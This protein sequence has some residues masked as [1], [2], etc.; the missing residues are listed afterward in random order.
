MSSGSGKQLSHGQ[1]LF[2][3]ERTS[4]HC[5]CT[6]KSDIYLRDVKIWAIQMHRY[7]WNTKKTSWWTTWHWDTFFSQILLQSSSVSMNQPTNQ[8]SNQTTNQPTNQL[9]SW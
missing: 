3:P 5:N 4:V 8:P 9:A 6:C 7:I 2:T 1:I